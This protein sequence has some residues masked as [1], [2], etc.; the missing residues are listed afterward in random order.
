MKIWKNTATLDKYCPSLADSCE[1]DVAEIAVVGGKPIDIDKMPRLRGIFKCGVGRDNIPE[2][3]CAER[4]IQVCFPSDKTSS[5]IFEET[6]NFTVHLIFRMLYTNVGSLE[7]WEKIPRDFLGQKKV[8]LIGLGNIGGR[9][10]DKLKPSI[11]I[12]SFDI[13]SNELEELP[14][15]MKVA[16][17]V[18]LH[19][20]LMESTRNFID[21]E[22]LS[23]M[24]KGAALVNTARGPLVDEQALLNEIQT[25]R[26]NA[27]FDVFWEEPYHGP[28]RDFHPDRFL[29]S[30]HV[31]S[32]CATFLEGLSVD[33]NK[34][35]ET[36]S[37]TC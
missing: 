11:D 37:S 36:L 28:L 4:G 1:S 2:E 15:M 7:K 24:K 20:P 25:G 12:L 16:D 21:A 31:A 27:A 13:L 32:T 26:L 35:I 6:A 19:I 8:L 29:M 22:K 18:A 14:G 33:L 23:W 34:F 30:P 9:V 17:V 3:Q 10:K 5:I